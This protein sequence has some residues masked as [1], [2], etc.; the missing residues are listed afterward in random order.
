[1]FLHSIIGE[2]GMQKTLFDFDE[3]AEDFEDI[4]KIKNN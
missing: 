3:E 4:H 2:R 1:M